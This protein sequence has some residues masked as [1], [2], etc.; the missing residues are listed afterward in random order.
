[1]AASINHRLAINVL[2]ALQTLQ[3]RLRSS[4][5]ASDYLVDYINFWIKVFADEILKIQK[6]CYCRYLFLVAVFYFPTC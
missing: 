5:T 4:Q 6:V 1:M 2:T 3:Q